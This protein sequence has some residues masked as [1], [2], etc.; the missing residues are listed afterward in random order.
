MGVACTVPAFIL[1]KELSL[2]I[3]VVAVDF[4]DIRRCHPTA[5]AL[6]ITAKH[7]VL[8]VH[9][10]ASLSTPAKSPLSMHVNRPCANP[11]RDGAK[12]EVLLTWEQQGGR[13]WNR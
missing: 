9:A 11:L 3:E 4:V 5:C 6:S 12:I 7:D 2:V 1:C 10:H 8:S 13:W